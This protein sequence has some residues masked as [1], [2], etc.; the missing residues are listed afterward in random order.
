MP[1]NQNLLESDNA[2]LRRLPGRSRMRKRTPAFTLIEL[3]VAVSII[4]VLVAILLPAL[5][6]AREAARRVVCASNLRSMGQILT[7]YALDNNG[8]FL[9]WYSTGSSKYSLIEI[10]VHKLETLEAL[11]D[12]Y[13]S[14]QYHIFDCPNLA[15]LFNYEM[16]IHQDPGR[17]GQPYQG[18]VYMGFMYLGKARGQDPQ[19]VYL[20]DDWPD[21][22]MFGNYLGPSKIA[23]SIH[24]LPDVPL[25]VD[26]A[27]DSGWDNPNPQLWLHVGHFKRGGGQSF[28]LEWHETGHLNLGAGLMAGSNHLYV[29]GHVE[30]VRFEEMSLTAVLPHFS[31][32]QTAGWWRRG[33]AD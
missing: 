29:D 11:F 9:P 33:P 20:Q 25:I 19:K 13:A 8:S 26:W 17:Y 14:G 24:D 6:R 21:M 1:V 31:R 28:I 3:L 30:W 32:P 7:M 2:A 12:N 16:R 23:S 5:S 18:W 10:G 22:D 15:G 4:A 27:N